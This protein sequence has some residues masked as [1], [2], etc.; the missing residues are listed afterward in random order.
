MNQPTC[1]GATYGVVWTATSVPSVS[2][3]A[4]CAPATPRY[5]AAEPVFRSA[6]THSTV[7]FGWT[8]GYLACVYATSHGDRRDSP[9]ASDWFETSTQR[10]GV[11]GA[12]PAARRC[13]IPE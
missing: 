7:A 1:P 8:V 9:D 6:T 3:S 13:A 11:T 5:H 2:A 10:F 12:V 4:A